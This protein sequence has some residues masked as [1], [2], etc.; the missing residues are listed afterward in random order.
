MPWEITLFTVNRAKFSHHSHAATA[1]SS[2]HSH[3]SSELTPRHNLELIPITNRRS[4]CRYRSIMALH[5]YIAR[6]RAGIL[7]RRNFR[8][9]STRFIYYRHARASLLR[10]GNSQCYIHAR[11]EIYCRISSGDQTLDWTFRTVRAREFSTVREL[12]ALIHFWINARWV[13]FRLVGDKWKGDKTLYWRL[14]SFFFPNAVENWNFEWLK[15]YHMI[16]LYLMY[17]IL[18]D[19]DVNLRISFIY[20]MVWDM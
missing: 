12:H 11:K 14:F 16:R 4:Q 5:C 18:F 2:P 6:A 20:F 19:W 17:I 10:G 9:N 7:R 1:A 15:T 8:G 13:S 3:N